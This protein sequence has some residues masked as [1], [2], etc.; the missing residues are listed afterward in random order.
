[1]AFAAAPLCYVLFK[2]PGILRQEGMELEGGW[3][4]VWGLQDN[5]PSADAQLY[6]E[7]GGHLFVEG[8]KA[9]GR[10]QKGKALIGKK[11]Q[12]NEIK[13]LIHY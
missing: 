9:A 7:D 1:M 8:M 10:R 5:L 6:W 4:G 11:E 12:Q 3:A 2:V 13:S